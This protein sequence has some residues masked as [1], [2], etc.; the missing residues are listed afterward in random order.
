[1]PDIYICWLLF[2]IHSPPFSTLFSVLEDW[3]ICMDHVNGLPCPLASSWVWPIGNLCRRWEGRRR[4]RK[5][6]LFLKLFQGTL[7]WVCSLIEG[8]FLLKAA[9]S[10]L[11]YSP[12]SALPLPL[13]LIPLLYLPQIILI[14]A[15]ICFLLRLWLIYKW[16]ILIIEMLKREALGSDAIL[17]L[18]HCPPHKSLC[19]CV[20]AQICM[21]T[22]IE[23]LF[24]I[25]E[26]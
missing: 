16:L 26:K 23:A 18:P 14:W 25:A 8:H 12:A 6:D 5:E 19:C 9:L 10:S 3:L 13:Y 11:I 7:C 20:N 15:C 17:H 2:H 21:L 4:V 1:M 24:I 22:F